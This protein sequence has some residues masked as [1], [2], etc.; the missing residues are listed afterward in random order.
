M[1]SKFFSLMAVVVLGLVQSS[2]SAFVGNNNQRRR[3]APPRGTSSRTT[4]S[5]SSLL[6]PPPPASTLTLAM[7][8][9]KAAKSKKSASKKATVETLRKKDLVDVVS[10]QMGITKTDADG[11]VT[12]VFDTIMD[13]VAD[14]KRINLS[15]F[16]TFEPRSRAA[17]KGRNPATGEEIDIAASTAVG[18]SAAKSFKDRLNGR[19]D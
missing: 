16:G 9:K 19:A 7:A 14:G 8:P 1:L 5:T 13:I 10:E 6:S 11:A 2:E 15:G 12:A 3:R 4:S 17:R 18:F